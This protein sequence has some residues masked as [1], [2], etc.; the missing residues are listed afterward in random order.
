MSQAILGNLGFPNWHIY[1]LFESYHFLH[2]KFLFI[3]LFVNTLPAKKALTPMYI[4]ILSSCVYTHI[5]MVPLS[6][7]SQFFKDWCYQSQLSQFKRSCR[8]FTNSSAV[9][10]LILMVTLMLCV[11]YCVC[12]PLPYFSGTIPSTA[13]LS[14]SMSHLMWPKY[15]SFQNMTHLMNQIFFNIWI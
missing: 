10:I 3:Q 9:C 6:P 4:N 12:W 11:H 13:F 1:T 15:F 8:Y 14:I 2:V 5:K 7:R